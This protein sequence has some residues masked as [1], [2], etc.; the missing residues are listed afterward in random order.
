MS[1]TTTPPASDDRPWH[2]SENPFEAMYQHF[3]AKM[4]GTA[5]SAEVSS[6]KAEIAALEQRLATALAAPTSKPAANPLPA[7]KPAEPL[8]A[9]TPAA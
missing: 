2:H 7:P 5:T 9:T 8:A 4:H 1:T 6:L 3:T